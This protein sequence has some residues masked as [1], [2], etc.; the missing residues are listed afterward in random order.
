MGLPNIVIKVVEVG[1][2]EME[3][4]NLQEHSDP[5]RLLCLSLARAKLKPRELVLKA[6]GGTLRV[7]V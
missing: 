1:A 3:W 7:P 4:L 2:G 6:R 5:N